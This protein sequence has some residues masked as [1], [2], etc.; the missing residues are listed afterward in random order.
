[1]DDERNKA[2]IPNITDEPYRF[3]T[4]VCTDGDGFRA[5][6]WFTAMNDDLRGECEHHEAG[7]VTILSAA[8]PELRMKSGRI[9][10]PGSDRCNDANV[11]TLTD[12]TEFSTAVN[13]L[14]A[15]RKQW[16]DEYA[17]KQDDEKAVKVP[18]KLMKATASA[19][20][21]YCYLRE[22]DITRAKAVIA[23]LKT[24]KAAMPEDISAKF[25]A[26]KGQDVF[27]IVNEIHLGV[28]SC[29][30][31]VMQQGC[32]SCEY[33]KEHGKCLS[34]DSDYTRVEN[35]RKALKNA[36]NKAYSCD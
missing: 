32:G 4:K 19:I 13:A 31:C 1:M 3:E 25:T 22:D 36:I 33:G 23:E 16:M 9:Y 10:I 18:T 14:I 8:C 21:T 5:E 27:D 15:F 35:T 28:T 2:G 20:A 17:K 34:S 7:G 30:Y 12:P 26:I 6:L 24:L 11:L 29:Q